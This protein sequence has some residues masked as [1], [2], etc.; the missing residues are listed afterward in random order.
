MMSLLK[1]VHKSNCARVFNKYDSTCPRC[2]ELMQGAKPRE[3]WGN[4][5]REQEARDLRGIS[6]HFKSEK[7]LRGGCGPV[8]TFGD[9]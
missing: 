7:H 4:R 1:V 5:K 2:Q 6:A 8:C 9:P 3:G